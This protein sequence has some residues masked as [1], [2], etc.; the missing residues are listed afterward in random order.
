MFTAA[1]FVIAKE[2]EKPECPSADEWA[3]KTR[4]IRTLEYYLVM[5]RNGTHTCY[6]MDEPRK[7]YAKGKEAS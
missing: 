5:K 1:V 7:H 6:S 3:N 4:S 2:Q